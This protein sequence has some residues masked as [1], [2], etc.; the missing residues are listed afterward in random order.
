MRGLRRGST[1]VE[2][3]LIIPWLTVLVIG[4]AEFSMYVSHLHRLQRAARDGAR[5]GQLTIE[6][7]DPDGSG[8][9]AAA[10]GQAR[11]VLA[12]N[13]VPCGLSDGCSATAEWLP[14]VEGD[15]THW[16]VVSVAAP[17]GSL[18]NLLPE[19]SRPRMRFSMVTQQ[20]P[21][22]P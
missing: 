5:V 21:P 14:L 8:I 19:L 1:A 20:Q 10:E 9:I 11:Q 22:P 17:Y 3:V 13:G 16:V 12:A 4:I 6:G 18:S 7:P 2:F 15:D